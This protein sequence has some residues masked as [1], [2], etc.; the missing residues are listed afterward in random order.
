MGSLREKTSPSFLSSSLHPSP[1][2]FSPFTYILFFDLV[3]METG[4]HLPPACLFGN[5][6]NRRGREPLRLERVTPRREVLRIHLAP[7]ASERFPAF[8]HDE[9]FST[10]RNI[11]GNGLSFPLSYHQKHVLFKL[12]LKYC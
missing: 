12:S 2:S 3:T 4:G 10:Q 7:A 11:L 1:L 5:N 6:K 9:A 8:R